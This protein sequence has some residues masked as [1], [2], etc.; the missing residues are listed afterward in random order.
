MSAHFA[1]VNAEMPAQVA[2]SARHFLAAVGGGGVVLDLGCGHA[3]DMMWLEARGLRL[4]GSD[5][6]RGML[7]EATHRVDGPLVQ[8]DMRLPAFRDS[9]FQGVWCNAAILHLPKSD[10]LPT[11][12]EIRRSLQPGGTLF[13]SIQVGT[14]ETWERG[15]YEQPVSRFFARYQPEEFAAYL[16]QAG[17]TLVSQDDSHASP[18]RHW[19]HYL[20]ERIE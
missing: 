6:S 5:L 15:A 17:F 18:A 12:K 11:L 16:K 10:V 19:A 2:E 4:V 8:M 9:A 20:T 7:S 14:G 3:R 1:L 13:I